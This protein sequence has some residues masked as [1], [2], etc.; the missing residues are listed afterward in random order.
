MAP[1]L[2]VPAIAADEFAFA[3]PTQV[4]AP[5]PVIEHVPLAFAA[6]LRVAMTGTRRTNQ[7]GWR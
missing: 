3:A 7:C 2:P 4:T 5:V 6:T 1:T